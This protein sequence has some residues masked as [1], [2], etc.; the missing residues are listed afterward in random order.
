VIAVYIENNTVLWGMQREQCI[1]DRFIYLFIWRSFHT[2]STADSTCYVLTTN[3]G[4]K[5]SDENTN[6]N[7]GDD[8]LVELK[9]LSINRTNSGPLCYSLRIYMQRL[10]CFILRPCQHDNGYMDGRSQI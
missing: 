8:N 10:V 4:T 1:A 7:H 5:A 3:N 9:Y 2:I 6:K